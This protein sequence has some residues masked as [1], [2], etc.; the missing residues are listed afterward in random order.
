MEK[1]EIDLIFSKEI[2]REIYFDENVHFFELERELKERYKKQLVEILILVVLIFFN[3]ESGWFWG[4]IIILTFIN[5]YN[6]YVIYQKRKEIN[7]FIKNVEDYIESI[8]KFKKHQ[9]ILEEKI[10][11]LKQDEVLESHRWG[12]LSSSFLD[13]L[14]IKLSFSNKNEFLI[15]LKSIEKEYQK[16]VLDFVRDRVSKG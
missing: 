11:S 1:L 8:D 16:Q 14:R 10:V 4:F 7:H 9:L 3:S 6:L 5:V 12:S 15:P 13:N 2:F